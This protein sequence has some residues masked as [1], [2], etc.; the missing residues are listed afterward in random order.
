MKE[1]DAILIGLQRLLTEV[2]DSGWM[3]ELECKIQ[4]FFTRGIPLLM[5]IDDLDEMDRIHKDAAKV[6]SMAS[7]LIVEKSPEVKECLSLFG[8]A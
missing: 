7:Y 1:I 3:Y 6:A 8:I 2:K 4:E 5:E